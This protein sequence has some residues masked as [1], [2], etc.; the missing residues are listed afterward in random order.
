[1]IDFLKPYVYRRQIIT[2]GKYYIGK[3][4]GNNSRCKGSGIDWVKD[5]N[6][7]YFRFKLC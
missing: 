5:Y 6:S 7:I 1:M 3:H 4:K 2:T